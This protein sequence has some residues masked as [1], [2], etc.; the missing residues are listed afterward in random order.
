MVNRTGRLTPSQRLPIIIAGV[1][2][3]V[4]MLC[5]ISFLMAM[6]FGGLLNAAF[7]N[8]LLGWLAYVLIMLFSLGSFIFLWG[9]VWTNAKMFLPEAFAKQPVRWAK[10]PLQ[11]KLAE[12]E[13]PEM[14]FSYIIGNYSFAPF[15]APD[16][17][18][19]IKNQEYIVYYTARSRLLLS[20][21]PLKDAQTADWL[22]IKD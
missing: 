2:S 18:P 15:V 3:G 8:G 10:A 13:R 22:P 9:V 19:L 14:P 4:G 12:R 16:E 7:V 11:I 1:V 6:V 21:A 20:I 5:P 17:V